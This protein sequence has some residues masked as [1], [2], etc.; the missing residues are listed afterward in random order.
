[1]GT[2]N[3]IDQLMTGSIDMHVHFGPES[4]V[5]RRQN[6]LQL[7]Y[8]AR[9]LK[10]KAIVLK[11]REY[12]TVPT[13]S[14][15]NQLVPEIQLFGSLTLDNE[16]GGINPSA[17]IS[18]ARMGAKVIWLPVFTSENSKP[19]AEKIMGIKLPGGTQNILDGHGKL[20]TEVI[21]ILA[22]VKDF[23]IVLA[24]GHIS[25]R[26]I[27]VLSDECSH[28]GFNKLLI[29]HALQGILMR[30]T[31]NIN[32]MK[33]LVANGVTIEHSFWEWMPTLAGNSPQQIVDL[34]RILGAEHCIM[35]SDMGQSYNPPAPEGLR[36]F[37]AT[38]LRKGLQ[39]K[40]IEL[41]VK[42]NPAKLLNMI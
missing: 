18:A 35:S 3:T 5:E 27:F 42:T 14:L 31:L 30:E 25:P 2:L 34:I 21:E 32:E 26:E 16:T 1:V 13:A 15:V 36:L 39:E 38:M 29:T 33:Q 41:M 17:V 28:S 20:R 4:L 6:A 7:A 37:I 12:N 11:N 10:M 24:T 23:D 40:E 9:E 22:I 19:N 8:T